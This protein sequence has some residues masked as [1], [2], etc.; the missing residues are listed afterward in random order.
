M[1]LEVIQ[2]GSYLPEWSYMALFQNPRVL[3]KANDKGRSFHSPFF[4]A[5]RG[6]KRQTD[7]SSLLSHL[8]FEAAS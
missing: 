3:W 2:K 7:G 4:D 1:S 8:N 5:N 6:V